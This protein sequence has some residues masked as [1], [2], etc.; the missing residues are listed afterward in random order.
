MTPLLEVD[1]LTI[2]FDQNGQ[3]IYALQDFEMSL[4]PGEI[5]GLIGESG[6]G[7]SAL[8]SA[9]ARLLPK[10][11]HIEKGSILFEGSN[12]LRRS[13]KKMQRVY[14][15]KLSMIFQDPMA[16]LCP[17]L[18]IKTQLI[19]I[20]RRHSRISKDH[21]LFKAA[22]LLRDV[23]IIDAELRLEQY[24]HE[25]SGGLRQR[26]LIAI[27]AALKPKLIIADEPTASLDS[28]NAA[29]V[30]TL[31]YTLCRRFG[32]SLILISHDLRFVSGLCDRL[33]VLYAG[34][35]VESGP[36]SEI[37]THPAHPYTRGLIDS[38][39]SLSQ[40]RSKPLRAIPG[41]IHAQKEPFKQCPFFE[42]CSYGMQTCKYNV[43]PLEA[44]EKDHRC[45]C[46]LYTPGAEKRLSEFKE[47]EKEDLLR[48]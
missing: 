21:A 6:S 27:A 43:P 23:G 24:P 2:R 18:K 17:T 36:A 26:V 28:M 13:S 19:E 15:Q 5:V 35:L 46:H 32:S 37:F 30:R 31:L 38:I 7:K 8:A 25:L 4:Y 42:R 14:G 45:A 41:T 22:Q 3:S 48:T 1:D 39:P 40:D 34:K 9:I 20:F 16:A 33:Y 29:S 12:L 44:I 47:P 11:G 10:E